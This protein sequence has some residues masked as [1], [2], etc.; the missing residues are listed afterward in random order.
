MFFSLT[1]RRLE[2]LRTLKALTS[3]AGSAVHYSVVGAQMRISAW[4]AY[5]LL[6][7]LE[8]LGLVVRRYVHGGA[9]GPGGRSRI[10]FAPAT[11]EAEDSEEA[12]SALR[13]AFERFSAMSDVAAARDYLAAQTSDLAYHMG[14]WL[15]RLQ[16]AGRQGTEAARTVLEG[17][18]APLQKAQT[19]AA[20]GLG[21]ALARLGATR[22][23]ARV[24]EAGGRFATLLEESRE[25]V[26]A[27]VEASRRLEVI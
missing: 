12:G 19:L 24:A 2:T 21:A 7:E 3:E 9:A 1:P 23:T 4:T 6:R 17:G 20:M 25:R 11:A 16:V 15:S 13:T 27:L 10:L 26:P 22:L 14:F 18:A 5:D 8:N